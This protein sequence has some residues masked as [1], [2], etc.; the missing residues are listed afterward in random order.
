[1]CPVATGPPIL[2]AAAL[3]FECSGEISE[4]RVALLELPSTQVS[5]FEPNHLSVPRLWVGG[6]GF[7][8]C[9][10]P[11]G[12]RLPTAIQLE[13]DSRSASGAPGPGELPGWRR[14]RSAAP[15][16]AAKDT[17]AVSTPRNCAFSPGRSQAGATR[18]APECK[19]TPSNPQPGEHLGRPSNALLVNGQEATS[20]TTSANRAQKPEGESLLPQQVPQPQQPG[21]GQQT[22]AGKLLAGEL[23]AGLGRF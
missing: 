17:R 18:E 2:G 16:A 11:S 19:K 8:G 7:G 21:A 15:R 6:S 10:L 12:P 4:P 9:P 5:S 13:A 23:R 22:P 20:Q 1:M 3:A 14:W